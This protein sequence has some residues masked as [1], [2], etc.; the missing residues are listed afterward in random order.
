MCK[1]YDIHSNSSKIT[2]RVNLLFLLIFAEANEINY[3]SS[4]QKDL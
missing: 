2:S 3:L 1:L 4:N